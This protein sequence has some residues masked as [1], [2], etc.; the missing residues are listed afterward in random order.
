MHPLRRPPLLLGSIAAIGTAGP[1]EAA[2]LSARLGATGL[3][4]SATHDPASGVLVGAKS[5][6]FL[7]RRRS[8]GVALADL[9]QVAPDQDV[10]LLVP[11]DDTARSTLEVSARCDAVNRIW[12][13]NGDIEALV[14]W[15]SWD[16]QVMLLHATRSHKL[17]MGIERIAATQAEKRITGVRLHATDWT[18]GLVA[19]WHRFELMAFAWD[20][21]EPH[22]ISRLLDMGVDAIAGA[23]V[24]RLAE[25]LEEAER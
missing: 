18:G 19:L 12:L 16:S 7:G 25:A 24:D 8:G 20:A 2:R 1:L 23:H 6:G 10:V 17:G 3:E 22:V 4:A 15:R 9:L 11:D 5:L 13:V 21:N 14:R